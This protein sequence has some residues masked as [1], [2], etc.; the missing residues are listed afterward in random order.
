MPTAKGE[1]VTDETTQPPI[2]LAVIEL[3]DNEF[4]GDVALA[5]AEFVDDETLQILDVAT[6][7]RG[8]GDSIERIDLE[9]DD[10]ATAR[11][12]ELLQPTIKGLLTPERLATVADQLPYTKPVA[13]VVWEDT[14]AGRLADKI[15]EAG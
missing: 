2:E 9:K 7:K 6:V 13:V 15:A 14:W 1:T 5:L 3:P 11:A 10:S 12:F 4:K 8:Y